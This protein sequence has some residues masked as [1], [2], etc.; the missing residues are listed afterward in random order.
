MDKKHISYHKKYKRPEVVFVGKKTYDIKYCVIEHEMVDV[1]CF[2]HRPQNYYDLGRF[3]QAKKYLK[4]LM[5]EYSPEEMPG[6][7]DSELEKIKELSEKQKKD[8]V[9][10]NLI[11][12]KPKDYFEFREIDELFKPRSGLS[13]DSIEIHNQTGNKLRI[14][15]FKDTRGI[16]NIRITEEI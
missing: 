14:K 12:T 15:I 1:G 3:E 6:L 8:L 16:T 11:K 5:C 10:T 7:D 4:E 9:E 13:H 2:E